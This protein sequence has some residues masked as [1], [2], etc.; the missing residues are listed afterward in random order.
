MRCDGQLLAIGDYDALFTLIGTTYGGDGENNFALPDLRGRVP[1]HRGQGLSNYI[2]GEFGGVEFVNVTTS[3]IPA[4]THVIDVSSMTATAR[5]RNGSATTTSPVGAVPAIEA[6]GSYTDSTLIAGVT[7]A[8]AAHIIELRS[9][10]DSGRV[11]NG[12]PAFAY[13]DSV[14]PATTMIRAQHILELRTALAQVYTQLGLT[15][16]AYTDPLLSA[17][18]TL[19][20]VHISELRSAAATVAVLGNALRYTDAVVDAN[21]ASSSATVSGSLAAMPSGGNQPHNNMQPFVTIMYCI[22]V[23]HLPSPT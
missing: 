16:P 21:M 5:C 10:I 7:T 19:K 15:Q 2:I 9:R 1:I 14:T 13:A 12:L 20:A 3:Q 17:G 11:A 18:Q 6:V 4:H 22:A 23:G 8:K